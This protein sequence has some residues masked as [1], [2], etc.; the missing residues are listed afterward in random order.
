[1]DRLREETY[2]RRPELA[3][4]NEREAR[5][6]IERVGFC[7]LFPVKGMELPSLWEAINGGPRPIPIHHHDYPLQLT[8]E[9]KDTLPSQGQVYYGKVLR[10]KPTFISLSLLPYFYALTGNTGE[11]E[12]YLYLY[13]EGKLS[14]EARRI[15]EVLRRLGPSTTGVLRREGGLYGRDKAARFDRAL[16]ELQR[17][18]LIVKS[19]ISDANRWKYCYVYDLFNRRFPEAVEEALKIRGR[20]AMEVI[21]TKYLEVTIASTPQGLAGLLGWSLERVQRVADPLLQRGVLGEVEVEG[22]GPCL[23][24]ARRRSG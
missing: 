15:Y 14:D 20:E 16:L 13:Q 7:L 9:W 5:G 6:F 17:S 2:H 3:L 8:W 18:F 22:L 12:E 19:G 11:E 4:K 21:M 1:L 24:L 23:S 10:N